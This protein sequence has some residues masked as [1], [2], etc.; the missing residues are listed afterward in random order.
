VKGKRIYANA[1]R[2]FTDA[3]AMIKSALKI[4]YIAKNFKNARIV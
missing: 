2:K 3:K 1:E 4:D